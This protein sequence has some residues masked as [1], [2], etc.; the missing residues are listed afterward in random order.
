MRVLVVAEHDGS[1]LR[2]AS[3][4]ALGFADQ[5]AAQAD[6]SVTCLLIGSGLNEV[7]RDA[8]RFADV[9]LADCASHGKPTR[10]SK[11]CGS[12]CRSS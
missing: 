3:R 1:H 12:A 6:G 4:C 2:P 7:A 10:A 5:L 11:P 9:L 8:A